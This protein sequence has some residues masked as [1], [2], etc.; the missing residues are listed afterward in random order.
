M[1]GEKGVDMRLHDIVLMANRIGNNGTQMYVEIDT[2]HDIVF[3]PVGDYRQI[4]GYLR[5]DRFCVKY[6]DSEVDFN[7]F[8][9]AELSPKSH[10]NPNPQL[11]L[12]G[13]L[14]SSVAH[15]SK[16]QAEIAY[17]RDLVRQKSV[18]GVP[19]ALHQ[20]LP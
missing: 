19:S 9:L 18:V 4:I 15:F 8:E 3:V 13:V 11:C 1:G 7:C 14:K 20:F 12:S 5:F 16:Y 6:P 2:P 10:P 17:L